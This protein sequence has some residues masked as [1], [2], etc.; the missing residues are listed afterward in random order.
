MENFIQ[1]I[2]PYLVD[3][4]GAFLILTGQ[5]AN[6]IHWIGIYPLNEVIHSSYNRVLDKAAQIV[7]TY[8]LGKD[9]AI[10]TLNSQVGKRHQAQKT[11]KS[12]QKIFKR[13]V[14]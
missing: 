8:S 6:F 1:R 14:S 5:R 7:N 10:Q 11:V 13:Q 9:C 4:I 12:K 3:K 2:N